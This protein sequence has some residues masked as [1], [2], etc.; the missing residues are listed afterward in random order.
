MPLLKPIPVTDETRIGDFVFGYFLIRITCPCGHEREPRGEFV[1]RII[2]ID[3]TFRDLR[4][5]LRCHKCGGRDA[6]VNV[7]RLPR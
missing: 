1:R 6:T 7:F 2:G 5:R 3:T 4:R